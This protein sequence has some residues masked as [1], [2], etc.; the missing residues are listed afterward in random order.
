MGRLSGLIKNKRGA[1]APLQKQL[2]QLHTHTLTRLQNVRRKKA[3]DD[4]DRYLVDIKASTIIILHYITPP[5]HPRPLVLQHLC[6]QWKDRFWLQVLDWANKE[7]WSLFSGCRRGREWAREGWR[8]G[9]TGGGRWRMGEKNTDF[10]LSFVFER[11]L[12]KND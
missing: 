8:E 2:L 5:L 3:A 9:S 4:P 7:Q 10:V 12:A 1:W 6:H 11:Q